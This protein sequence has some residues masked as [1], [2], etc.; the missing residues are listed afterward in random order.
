MQIEIL[1]N[2]D[3]PASPVALE[4]AGMVTILDRNGVGSESFQPFQGWTGP[5]NI[6]LEGNL[7]AV[8]AGYSGGPRV[9]VYDINNLSAPIANFYAYATNFTGGVSVGF[10][11][12]LSDGKPDLITGPGPTGGPNIK[13]WNG[14]NGYSLGNSFYLGS[15][16]NTT[17]ITIAVDGSALANSINDLQSK[18][19]AAHTLYLAFGPDAPT[20]SIQPIWQNVAN[21]FAPW[22]VN[23][24]TIQPNDPSLSYAQ[25]NIGGS[26]PANSPNSEE[27][28][29]ANIGG[30]FEGY[31]FAI[32]PAQVYAGTIGW[33]NITEIS[34][35]V[36]HEAGHLYGLEHDNSDANSIMYPYIEPYLGSWDPT[37]IALLNTNLGIA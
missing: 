37:S 21:L 18:P 20:S 11:N 6:A 22:N 2:R 31:G 12:F 1:E 28:G 3:C 29:Q 4:S 33:S 24:T 7:L 14:S 36:A 27:L 13:Y 35:A 10:G 15:P 16:E 26:T 34:H 17:G 5:L 8:G 25:V 23:V 19:G 9:S 30:A 32:V